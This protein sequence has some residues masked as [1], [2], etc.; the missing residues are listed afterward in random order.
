MKKLSILALA[1]LLIGACSAEREATS[2]ITVIGEAYAPLLALDKMKHEYEAR[3]GIVVEIVQKDHMTVVQELDQQF[4]TGQVDY[5][6]ILMPHRLLGKLVENDRVFSLAEVDPLLAEVVATDFFQPWAAEISSY[7]GT[8]YGAPFTALTMYIAYRE[9]LFADPEE[10]AAFKARY[11]RELV[12]AKTWGEY[13]QLAE[14]FTRPED[15]LYGTYIQGEQNISLW[16]EWLNIIYSFGGNVIA[17]D[18]GSDKG[19]VVVNSP[20]NVQATELYVDLLKY[21]PPGA[22]TYDWDDALAALQTG[23]V[24]MGLLWHDQSPFLEDPEQSKTAGSIGY[25]LVPSTEGGQ[26][27]SQLEGW[28]YLIPK[29]SENPQRSADFIRWA[30]SEDV[31]VRQNLEGG[32]SGRKSTYENNEVLSLPY[33]KVFLESIPIGVAKPTFPE[34]AA[35]TEIIERNLS[36]VVTSQISSRE[37]LQAMESEIKAIMR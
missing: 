21:S 7:N 20:E 29:T 34:S 24:A 8:Y 18:R 31:Q 19:E 6:V 37:G 11:G 13:L 4:A 17:S 12:P 9:D 15:G 1:L 22:L 26:Q 2:K 32:A 16:Y 28:T 3:T 27:A 5:D 33:T 30:V 25:S 14:F 23:R 35:L 36:K 10:R